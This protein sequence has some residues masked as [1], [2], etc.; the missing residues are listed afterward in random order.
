M[1]TSLEIDKI[2]EAL[3]TAQGEFKPVEKNKTNPHF[4][5][6]YADLS[7]VIEATRDALHKN[8]L[9]ITQSPEFKDGRIE[10]VTRVL[11][12]SGQWLESTVS[13][14]PTQDNPQ[15]IGSAITYARRY[16]RAAILDLAADEDDDANEASKPNVG[17]KSTL[18]PSPTLPTP[19]QAEFTL[20][21]ESRN[22]II[23]LFK[24]YKIDMPILSKFVKTDEN[25]WNEEH[26]NKI[27]QLYSD[28]KSDKV[29]PYDFVLAMTEDR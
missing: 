3:A 21:K 16:G 18:R 25:R 1:N 24:E 5:N 11:H 9:F 17:F 20:P 23:Q 2:S 6:T 27:R 19:K 4:K 10:V 29:D 13:L 14:K 7:S 28:I 15:Q 22:V 26:V 12:K 8:G